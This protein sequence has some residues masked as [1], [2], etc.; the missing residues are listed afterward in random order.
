MRKIWIVLLATTVTTVFAGNWQFGPHSGFQF[1]RF[2]GEYFPGTGK[3]YFLGG[4]ISDLSTDGTIWGYDPG[5]QAYAQVG[6]TMLRCCATP[7]ICRRGIPTGF[8]SLAD[9]T[10]VPIS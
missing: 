4:R 8:M 5:T 1:T 6:A 9:A 10:I 2:D 3:V 7:M